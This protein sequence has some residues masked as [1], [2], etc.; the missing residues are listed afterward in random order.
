M[1][2]KG[3]VSAAYVTEVGSNNNSNNSEQTINKQFKTTAALNIRSD[4]S[5][6]ASVVGSLANNA[7]FKAVAQ[8]K[9]PVLMAIVPGIGWK[10]KAGSVVPM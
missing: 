3:W 6:S 5:T 8:N 7:T 1:E 10:A 9:E 4:A 2:G